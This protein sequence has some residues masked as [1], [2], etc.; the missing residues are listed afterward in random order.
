MH[1][2]P[3]LIV[4][5]FIVIIAII[6]IADSITTAVVIIGLIVNF[7]VICVHLSSIES[8]DPI[9]VGPVA[10]APGPPVRDAAL[11]GDGGSMI[12]DYI[13]AP[14]NT[15]PSPYGADYDIYAHA[16]EHVPDPVPFPMYGAA[17]GTIGADAAGVIMAQRRTRDKRA[18]NG[19]ASK[20]ADYFRYNF[21]T[22]LAESE[23]KQWW[24][25]D[26]Y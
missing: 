13:C 9:E 14:H 2:N 10:P 21:S 8:S 20:T 17:E 22:E 19:M 6:C 16:N 4:L 15:L 5:S 23:A 7:I 3:K 25:A 1:L 24:G 11:G 12:N 18:M 26:D